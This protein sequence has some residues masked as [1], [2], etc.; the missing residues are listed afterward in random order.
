MDEQRLT[1]TKAAIEEQRQDG[2]ALALYWK[3]IRDENSPLEL[4]PEAYSLLYSAW[5]QQGDDE[6]GVLI[7]SA[8]QQRFDDIDVLSIMAE[9]EFQFER[10]NNA[11]KLY[12]RLLTLKALDSKGYQHLKLACFKQQSFNDFTNLLLQR[13]LKL[14]P[15]DQS[16]LRFLFSQ[17]LLHEKFTYAPGA[18][19]VYQ[20][21]L[22]LEPENMSAHCALCE[23]YLRQGKYEESI[24]AGEAALRHEKSH[25]DISATLAKAHYETG[26]Y[27][28]V[29]TY[30]RDVLNKRHG[31]QDI[32]VLLATVYARN[33]LTTNE[34]SKHYQLALKYEAQNLPIRLALFRSYLRKL[35]VENALEECEQIITQLSERYEESNREFI[36]T[37]KEMIS[38]CER[39]LR[40]SP[41]DIA[42]YLVTAKLYE[43]IGH[44]NKALIYYRTLLEQPL[45]T[46]LQH[47][48]LEVLEK[49]ASFQ[50]KNPH[51]YLYLGLLYHK[52]E[53]PREAK[54][55]FRTVMYSE[56][57]E[58]EVDDILVRHDR[59]IWQ[60]PPVLVILAHHRLVTKDILEGLVQVFR[61]S[62]REDWKGALWVL[63][64][65]YDI[66]DLLPELRQVFEWESFAEIYQQ[67][68]TILAYNASQYALE[69]LQE[70]L[71]FPQE[72]IRRE[73]LNALFQMDP[74]LS[75]PCLIEASLDNPHPD[76]RLEI[77]GYYAQQPTAHATE[78]LLK[79]LHDEE[80]QIRLYVIRELQKR[81]LEAQK[82]REVLFIEQN[83][84]VKIEIVRFLSRLRDP[85]EV[86]YLA[87]LL[88]DMITKRYGDSKT[89]P[90]KV[91]S[92]IKELITHSQN[93]E[94][95]HLLSAL[96]HAAGKL[97][98]EESL[99]SLTTLAEYDRSQLLRI[100]AIEALAQ[101]GSARGIPCLQNILHSSLESQDIRAAAEEALDILVKENPL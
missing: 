79:L 76:I 53:R 6:I 80:A 68:I 85:K 57:D 7:E 61:E 84:E 70:L 11:L 1:H 12:D 40:R 54:Q 20:T 101:I 63:Q 8:Y 94:D 23:F 82:L 96:I 44:F 65:L 13:C 25:P 56:L 48:L 18:Q 14:Y 4:L 73:A 72:E 81:D 92:R 31:R 97:R 43:D 17:Y 47:K 100:E 41:D 93:S 45:Q 71:S 15:D 69:L 37:I 38:E 33:L 9:G 34:A 90:G 58:R 26:G 59:S 62:D 35:Q 24:Q 49:L 74:E 60:Y 27:G 64:E 67:L 51:L 78:Q 95:V 39:A 98:L 36:V 29:V 21:M 5:Y 46:S 50:V 86:I 88:N 22:E 3:C 32:Q 87:H 55:A 2:E 66:D 75:D 10:Y 16:I 89:T 52:A 30:C 28:K 77:A 42:L 19:T 99:Y 83:A 91:Y